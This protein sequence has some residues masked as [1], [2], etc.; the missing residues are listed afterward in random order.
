MNPKRASFIYRFPSESY[1]CLPARSGRWLQPN[2]ATLP[3]A[4]EISNSNVHILEQHSLER[5]RLLG[6]R[7]CE[8]P[9]EQP[10]RRRNALSQFRTGKAG[11]TIVQ[12]KPDLI[13]E[14]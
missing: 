3:G 2:L 9:A 11:H 5:L 1:Y 7:I 8:S 6:V 10:R 14:R 12:F 4:E 13:R